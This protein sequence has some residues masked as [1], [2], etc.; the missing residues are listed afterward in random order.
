MSSAETP[1]LALK[2]HGLASW[3]CLLTG[4][5][6]C[7]W[8][9]LQL[10]GG[11][12]FLGLPTV[13]LFAGSLATY[14][15]L[16]GVAGVAGMRALPVLVLAGGLLFVGH[17]RKLS[18]V[19]EGG[20]L[21]VIVHFAEHRTL[22][23]V[24]DFAPA[25]VV[26][27][28]QGRYP[29]PPSAPVEELGLGGRTYQ[30]VHPPLYY[31]LGAVVHALSPSELT[32]KLRNL[33]IFGVVLLAAAAWLMMQSA[34][35]LQPRLAAG[36]GFPVIA[37]A[38][39]LVLCPGILLRCSTL[40]NLCLAIFLA[41]LLCWVRAL[42]V[43]R[44]E[45]WSEDGAGWRRGLVCG[46]LALTH[47]FALPLL[48]GEFLALALVRRWR[49][50]GWA[51]GISA[52]CLAPWVALN[53]ARYGALTGGTV[54]W[55]LQQPIMNPSG[56]PLPLDGI[57]WNSLHLFESFWKAQEHNPLAHSLVAA[58]YLTG[59]FVVGLVVAVLR[60][61]RHG[62]RLA[63]RSDE[64]RLASL[65]SIL[66]APL[67]L[68]AVAVSERI[69]ILLG[70]YFFPLIPSLLVVQLEAARSLPGSWRKALGHA[71]LLCTGALWWSYFQQ[72]L[73]VR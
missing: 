66:V 25:A 56:Q 22:P 33:R 49:A 6:G 52:L 38:A 60:W 69:M 61:C 65:T 36:A 59:I 8:I 39:P 24:D 51:L 32:A 50:L 44:P 29:G 67:F 57:A 64:L 63:H 20:H 14:L 48:A 2:R 27:L 62:W 34:R 21:A 15:V 4:L 10:T 26:A 54:A 1:S 19:D 53:L 47:I 45:R 5:G 68:L 70:R 71:A 16:A 28:E 73:L 35:L 58:N 41:A 55:R 40:G 7:I 72:L 18:P 13:A 31:L 12:A 30:G 46:A 11:R 43:E 37:L 42:E 3:T 17:L 9:Y 23:R